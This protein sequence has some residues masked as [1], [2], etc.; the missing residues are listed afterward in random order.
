MI[1]HLDVIQAL[2]YTYDTSYDLTAVRWAC[3]GLMFW[4]E[5]DDTRLFTAR[6]HCRHRP[7]RADLDLRPLALTPVSGFASRT[8]NAG[9]PS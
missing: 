5:P 7:A 9:A 2:T 4:Y 6:R 1:A 3:H 8:A